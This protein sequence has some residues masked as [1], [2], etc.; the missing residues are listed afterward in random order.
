[1]G[2]TIQ[3]RATIMKKIEKIVTQTVTLNDLYE[4]TLFGGFKMFGWTK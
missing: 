1:M 4:K 2:K 3:N